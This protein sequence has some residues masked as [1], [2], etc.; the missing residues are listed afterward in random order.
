MDTAFSVATDPRA[1]QSERFDAQTELTKASMPS[2]GASGTTLALVEMMREAYED[3]QFQK[4]LSRPNLAPHPSFA[5]RNKKPGVQSVWLDDVQ[6]NIQGNWYERPSAFGF[7]AM[8]EMVHQTPILN[9][10]IMTRQRQV[11]RFCR[12]NVSGGRGEGFRIELKDPNSSPNEDQKK[13]ALLLQD[14]FSNCGWEKRARTRMRL[15][16]DD[17]TQFMAKLTRE[18]LSMDSMPIETEWKKDKALGIDG[19]YAVDGSTIRLCTEDGYDGDDEVFAL[20]LVQGQVRTVYTYDDLIYVPRNPRAD[21]LAGGYGLSETELL[22]RVVTGFLNAFTYNTKYFDSNQIPK[23]LLHLTGN[24]GE[25]DLAAFKR[26]WN[27][28][29]KGVNN[30]WSLPVLVSKDQESKAAFEHFGVE[31]NEIMFAKWMTFL[32][33]IA[34]AI[35]AISPTEINFEA[36]TAGTSSL[37]GDDTDEKMAHST[38]KGLVPLLSYYENLF[39]DYVVSEF[40]DD[41]CFRFTGL[42]DEKPETVFERQ[43]LVMTV[44]EMRALDNMEKISEPWGDAPLNPVIMGAWQQGQQQGQEDYG[45]PGQG[46][47]GGAP[48]AD[49]QQQD[50]QDFGEAEGEEAA[51]QDF[52]GETPPA[53]GEA[54][55]AG[56]PPD[57][58]KAWGLPV[59]G[60]R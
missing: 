46:G 7:S 27:S 39:T 57:M 52:G 2:T 32:T 16:R 40:G 36:F 28:M 43:K 23:G 53:D 14:F 10:I 15:G 24:Y 35:Y 47:E 3:E 55:P 33:S 11:S 45:D 34:C 48:P 50:G 59:Y 31:Q 19:M 41:F 44:N 18:T 37:S 17:F 21:V 9:A 8:K 54:P 4:S 20:Q 58:A 42:K 26:Y 22:I 5:V 29:V 60:I 51:G 56:D 1:P 12:Q 6:L 38:D 13:A 49:G 30:A 25:Q